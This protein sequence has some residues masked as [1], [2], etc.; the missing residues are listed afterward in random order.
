MADDA[1]KSTGAGI[2]A[3]APA[4]RRLP[5]MRFLLMVVVPV[6][7]MAAGLWFYL[8]GGRYISTDNAYVGAQKVLITPDISGRIGSVTAQE[9][10]RVKKGDVLFS[11]A[12]AT[13]E[14]NVKQAKAQLEQARSDY[15]NLK[16][17]LSSLG[18]QKQF[19]QQVIDARKVQ[20]ANNKAVIAK[21]FGDQ[22][23][24]RDWNA[25]LATSEAQLAQLQQQESQALA[26]LLGSAEL[27]LDQFP[28]YMQAAAQL[29]KAERDL[30][31]TDVK[32]PIDGIATQVDNI[33]VGRY[34]NAGA[35]VLAVIATG[36]PWVEANPKE[37][38]LTHVVPGQDV[39]ISVDTFPD[40]VWHG[41]VQSISPG[42]GAE[43]SI[44]PPQNA[45]GN[46]VKVVQR[47]PV[48]IAF[49]PG[50]D[51]TALR[52]GLSVSVSID[53]KQGRSFAGL[54]GFNSVAEAATA[55]PAA[56]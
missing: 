47:V 50:E 16:A 12:P 17:L 9:G 1:L 39:T 32:A 30:R 15:L 42:T 7:A 40:R 43:F 24:V 6:L 10:Q 52:A 44:L 25:T 55:T 29:D 22:E 41:K 51:T 35:P 4:K 56:P 11:I 14:S 33:Q 8:S 28:A 53:T 54:F 21:G 38:D 48:R 13:Y 36:A 3:A 37:T 19:A 2:P 31:N 27:P 18:V 49:A 34:L 5:K 23:A 20:L 45:A 26:R 46:W